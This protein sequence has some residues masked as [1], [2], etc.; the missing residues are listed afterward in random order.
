MSD[1]SPLRNSVYSRLLS[2]QIIALAGTGLSTV[3]LALLAYDLAE[4]DA[5]VVLG[6]ALALKMV[7]YVCIAPIVGGYAHKLPRKTM[8]VALDI[9]RALAIGCLPFVTEIWQIYVLIFFLNSCSAG[10]TPTYQA[11]IPDVLPDEKQY[12]KALSLSR[13][14][15]DLENLLSPLFAAAALAVLTYDALFSVN[16]AA[17]II[18]ALL[19]LSCSL[20]ASSIVQREKGVW[21][22]LTYGI[23]VYLRTPRL[24]AVLV[25]AMAVSAAGSMVIVNTVVYVRDYLGRSEQDLALVLMASGIGSMVVAMLLPKY[26]DKFSDKPVMVLGGVLMGSALFLGLL[27]PNFYQLM[28]IWFMLGAG[29]S[30]S[31]TPMGRLLAKSATQG[32]RPSIYAAQFTLSHACWLIAY[33]LAGWVGGKIGL[34]TAFLVLGVITV[35]STILALVIWPKNDNEELE[36]I[37]HAHDH[38]H[39]HYHD[40][41][42]DHDHEGWE[43]EEPHVHP[44]YHPKV[45]H[46]HAYVI[47]IHH[48]TWPK[49]GT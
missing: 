31:Q 5:G 13:L 25:L 12:T 42:H 14:A 34:D 27:E 33:P 30:M 16:A 40:E 41:H 38:E 4:G 6:T 28:P 15:Y 37:H 47:D 43:G 1:V 3:A 39:P 46:R 8:L 17:F 35:S 49:Q 10:F 29:S 32:D 22:N 2:A 36:H 44:H 9:G 7:A 18:S 45:R 48:E 23:S 11:T 24:R 20:P 19:V 21:K 26:L